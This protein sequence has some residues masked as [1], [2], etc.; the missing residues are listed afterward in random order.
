MGRSLKAIVTFLFDA[1]HRARRNK[2]GQLEPDASADEV[3]KSLNWGDY[4]KA[5][6]KTG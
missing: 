2:Q 6:Q 3:D 5:N 1:K 4:P